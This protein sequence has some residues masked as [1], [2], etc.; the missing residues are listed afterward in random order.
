VREFV[1]FLGRILVF[2]HGVLL[3]RER[4]EAQPR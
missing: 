1:H 2:R 4:L 3:K